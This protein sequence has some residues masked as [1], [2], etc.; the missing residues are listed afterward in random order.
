MKFEG[1]K[2][3][4]LGIFIFLGL[5]ILVGAIYYMGTSRQLFGDRVEIIA[6]FKN[7]EGLKE[8]NNV[9]FS[10]IKVGVVKQVQ[11]VS[12]SLVMA[13]LAIS[14]ESSDFIKKDSYASIESQGLMGNKVVTI[15][16]GSPGARSVEAGD[17]LRTREPVGVETIIREVK[18]TAE[19]ATKLAENLAQITSS[20]QEGQGTLGKLIYDDTLSTKLELAMS[21]ITQSTENIE[22]LTAEVNEVT[23]KLNEGDGLATRLINDEEWANDIDSTLDSLKRTSTMMTKATRDIRVFAEQLNEEKGAIQKLLQDSVMAEDLHQAIINVK[24][25]TEDLD[26]V[27]NTVNRSWILNLFGGSDN[28]D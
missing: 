17:E 12:D 10:G 28:D 27:L 15:S 6:E 1:S 8:G 20:I 14:A 19:Q 16:A 7:V 11:L 22:N 18:S 4:K 21:S 24:Q 23:R 2:K 5:I 26:K 25:G 9:W 13:R 3:F